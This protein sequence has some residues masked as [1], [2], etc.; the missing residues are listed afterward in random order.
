MVATDSLALPPHPPS[1][2]RAQL[3]PQVSLD[4]GLHAGV[5][6]SFPLGYDR[7]AIGAL[8]DF[9][10]E[11]MG[12]A[13]SLSRYFVNG[14]SAFNHAYLIQTSDEGQ[15][16]LQHESG[17]QYFNQ[18]RAMYRSLSVRSTPVSMLKEPGDTPGPSRV[19]LLLR[20]N[21]SWP[22]GE[23]NLF[24][25]GAITYEPAAADWSV[26]GVLAAARQIRP[27]M[28]VVA[29]Y[30]QAIS[31]RPS[32]LSLSA[33]QG[34][35]TVR[36]SLDAGRGN[37]AQGLVLTL[38]QRLPS[39][40]GLVGQWFRDPKLCV[41]YDMGWLT[42]TAQRMK[43]QSIGIYATINAGPSDLLFEAGFARPLSSPE[44]GRW[45]AGLRQALF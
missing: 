44:P 42:G 24:V 33:A 4:E 7:L 5:Q 17:L 41:H 25:G 12:L 27:G 26:L 37:Q 29:Q 38:Q 19:E 6:L 45:Y 11:R 30:G 39:P 9:T 18:E 35:V 15:L 20:G 21:Q 16:L 36:G 14:V 1:V 34:P 31:S 28:A 2:S 32:D 23:Q 13:G 10:H 43:A 40:P 8:W 3:G 22:L